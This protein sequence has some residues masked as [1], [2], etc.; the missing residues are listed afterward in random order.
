MLLGFKRRFAP[1]VEE[2]SK[3]HT[4]RDRGKRRSFIAGKDVCD[5]YVDP[6]RETMRLLGRW[7]CTRVQEVRIFEHKSAT[8]GVSVFVCGV[9]LD[10]DE[11]NSLAWRDGFRS[12]GRD[13]A[14]VEMLSFWKGRLPFVGDMIHWDYLR[15]V[16]VKGRS[17]VSMTIPERTTSR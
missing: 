16:Q 5:C 10:H 12:N 3:T 13:G 7:P 1:F 4:I 17:L 6:R 14:F 2:G 15:P 9:G 11:K 8:N